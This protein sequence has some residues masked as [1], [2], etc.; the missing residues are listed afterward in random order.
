MHEE[1]QDHDAALIERTAAG[2]QE[3]FAELYDRWSGRLMA[4]IIQVLV[5]RAQSEEVLQ[6]VFLE[7]WEGAAGYDRSRGSARGWMAVR[8]RRRAVDR[9][10]SSQAS[11]RRDQQ[12]HG[13]LPDADTTLQQVEDALE[14]EEVRRALRRVGE[15]HRSTLLLAYVAGLSHV[16]ISR[17][18]GVP[19]GT[20]K[21]RLRYGVARMRIEMGAGTGQEVQR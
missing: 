12:W 4:L 16:E 18:M 2:D 15:P 13:T 20:V 7:I 1:D 11:R 3:A 19:L 17:R 5:D 9:V 6:E 8:A 21:S 14:A 10:R